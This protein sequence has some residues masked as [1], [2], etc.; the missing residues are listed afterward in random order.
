VLAAPRPRHDQALAAR[1]PHHDQALTAPRPHHDQALVAARPHRGQATAAPRSHRGQA[2]AALS[3]LHAPAPTTPRDHLCQVPTVLHV[4][5]KGSPSKTLVCM[6]QWS[7]RVLV[8]RVL[9]QV[10]KAP[11]AL[12]LRRKNMELG[13]CQYQRPRSHHR[14]VSLLK[15]CIRIASPLL[16]QIYLLRHAVMELGQLNRRRSCQLILTAGAYCIF[17]Y[18][19]V[20]VPLLSECCHVIGVVHRR[21]FDV[22]GHWWADNHS[23]LTSAQPSIHAG[24]WTTCRRLMVS[25]HVFDYACF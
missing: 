11:T 3:I 20:G 15:L 5:V 19:S 22:F 12:N 7:H 2:L 14:R 9:G 18:F 10:W 8:H 23:R 6:Y 24:R 21:L 17:Y 4:L 1:R 13:W 25:D 16:E